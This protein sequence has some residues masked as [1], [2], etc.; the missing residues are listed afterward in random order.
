MIDD[1]RIIEIERKIA[2]QDKIIEDLNYVIIRQQK[3][4]EGLKKALVQMQEQ[5]SSGEQGHAPILNLEDE[6]PPHY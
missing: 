6:K 5:S 2:F 3:D 1:K 4:I